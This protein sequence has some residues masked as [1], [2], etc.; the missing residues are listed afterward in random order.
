[1]T[2]RWFR[3]ETTVEVGFEAPLAGGGMLRPVQ[4]RRLAV[5]AREHLDRLTAM[6]VDEQVEGVAEVVEE[7]LIG[8]HV[9]RA[10]HVGE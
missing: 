8:R 10:E 4:A 5:E 7:S 3:V 6:K 2:Q 9:V 1:M